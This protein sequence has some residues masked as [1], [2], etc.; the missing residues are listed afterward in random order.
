VLDELELADEDDA[1]E[2]DFEDEP[3][4]LDELL[5]DDVDVLELEE[6]REESE[7]ESLR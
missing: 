3:L 5:D 4:S 2:S 7:R 6:D 1:E